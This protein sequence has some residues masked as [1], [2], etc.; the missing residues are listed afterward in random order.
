MINKLNSNHK[1]SIFELNGTRTHDIMC[2]KHTFYPLNYKL[3]IA[4]KTMAVFI[5]TIYLLQ[6]FKW[7]LRDLNPHDLYDRRI[8]SPLRLPFRQIP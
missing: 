8:L 3:T 1:L 6:N 2:R 7:G 4:T 5:L